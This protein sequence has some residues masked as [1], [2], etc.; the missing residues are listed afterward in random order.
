MAH[1]NALKNGLMHHFL[2]HLLLENTAIQIGY[3][4]KVMSKLQSY[5]T[6]YSNCIV[7]N[8]LLAFWITPS[9]ILTLIFLLQPKW[10]PSSLNSRYMVHLVES[11]IISND[12]YYN[13]YCSWSF[14]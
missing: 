7:T 12:N 8:T 6:K 9:S 11:V 2:N 1:N 14:P 10:L 4:P 3:V 5:T 13:N